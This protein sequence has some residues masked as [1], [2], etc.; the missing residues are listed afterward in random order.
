MLEQT[1]RFGSGCCGRHCSENERAKAIA[2][3]QNCIQLLLDDEV[4]AFVATNHSTR[5]HVN[6][7]HRERGRELM[8]FKATPHQKHTARKFCRRDTTHVQQTPPTRGIA[9]HPKCFTSAQFG[10]LSLT[11]GQN[12]T[13]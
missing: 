2:S 5:V 12:T 10:Q 13:N 8:R 6:L 4:E 9:I 7:G 1:L 11:S 3:G